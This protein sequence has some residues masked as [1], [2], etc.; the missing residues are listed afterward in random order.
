M[1]S[2]AKGIIMMYNPQKREGFRFLRKGKDIQSIRRK[3]RAK[4][5]QKVRE[6]G[7]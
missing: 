5:N 4:Y 2:E 7:L 1:I 6:K 3:E